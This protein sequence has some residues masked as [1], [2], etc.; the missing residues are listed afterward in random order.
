MNIKLIYR[1]PKPEFNSIENVFNALLP[2]LK[3][4]KIELPYFSKGISDRLKNILFVKKLKTNIYHITGNDHYLILGLK[5]QKT[6]L[7]IHDIEILKRSSGI[8]RF[9]LK[10][11]WFDLPIK[12]A[13][14]VT[15]ISEFS[16]NEILSLGKTKSPIKVIYNPLTLP[17]KY[18]PKEF[19]A[20]IPTILHLGT[21]QNKNL[22][23]LI[24]AL[25]EV[26]CHLIIIGKPTATTIEQ[27]KSNSIS[28]TIKSNLSNQE[29]I[30]EYKNCD[31]LS[32]VSTY[33][34]FGLPIVE[35]QA[36]GRVVL[37]A[38]VASLPEVAGNGAFLVNPFDVNEIKNGILEL[39]NN[40]ELRDNLIKNGLENVKRF[41]PQHIAN[42][43]KELYKQILNEA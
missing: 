12:Y 38:N 3:V 8:K 22:E 19:N 29:V 39:I 28:Y 34:G 26:K 13:T 1:K 23:R 27:L 16:K 17:I 14:S 31:V 40:D 33:E 15:T 35:A 5:K 32:F 42:Q 25:K 2:Y 41:E 24:E 18:T 4:D 20:E 11:L 43:Y 36:M 37:T 30:E 6:I 9:I 10:K 7:T 21:K